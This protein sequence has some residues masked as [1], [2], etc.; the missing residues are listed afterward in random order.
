MNSSM[1]DWAGNPFARPHPGLP[2]VDRGLPAASAAPGPLADVGH[3]PTRHDFPEPSL[4]TGTRRWSLHDRHTEL[5][6]P[7]RPIEDST[8]RAVFGDRIPAVAERPDL[9]V[10]T[11][12]VLVNLFRAEHSLST[13][14]GA[15]GRHVEVAIQTPL[16][17]QCPT[18]PTDQ[19]LAERREAI[20]TPR[21]IPEASL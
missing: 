8:I 7:R 16:A 21:P 1:P 2:W 3:Q 15:R 14:V 10:P 20:G 9:G 17:E 12:Q 4:S 19:E 13:E 5:P 18:W 11:G 6:C